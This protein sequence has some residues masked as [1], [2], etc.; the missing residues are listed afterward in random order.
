VQQSNED[1]SYVDIPEVTF[2][3]ARILQPADN[4]QQAC[5][6]SAALEFKQAAFS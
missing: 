6:V 1:A 4:S 5:P 2:N 3:H